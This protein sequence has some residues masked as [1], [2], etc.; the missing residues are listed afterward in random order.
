[1]IKNRKVRAAVFVFTLGFGSWCQAQTVTTEQVLEHYADMV[2]ANYSD[3]LDSARD[4][5][6]A[7]QFFV[8]EPNASHMEQAK[9]AWQIGREYYGQTEAFRF[10]GGPIDDDNGP[11]G[12]INAWP[13]DESYVDSVANNE[14]TGLIN[15]PSFVINQANI[16]AQNERG[17][18][19]NVASGWHAIEF[20]LWGQD[21]DADGPGA[22]SYE[23]YVVGKGT[24]AKRRADYLQAVTALL[25]EDLE[26]VT[27][28]WESNNSANYRSQFVRGGVDSLRKIFIGIGSLSRGELA[29]ERMEVA[30]FSRD[31]EDEHSCFSDNTHRDIVT[32]A[33]GIRNVWTGSYSNLSGER[34]E[35]PALRHLVSA[36]DAT[37]SN[38]ITQGVGASV[39]AA[40]AIQPPFD[41]AIASDSGRQQI[42]QTIELLIQQSD[43]FVEAASIIGIDKLTYVEP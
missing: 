3:T 9:L 41:Q 22:R 4:V 30:L 25:V 6:H 23:D 14:L 34:F 28:Q 37:L 42:Q 40:L 21:I 17:G 12:Q 20:L 7:V 15:D 38:K 27:K 19:E 26:S 5:L 11:E 31:Q 1:M 32:N 13:M 24:N 43:M 36:F 33:L 35:G 2:Y 8:R 39:E 10:Y 29:G 16:A 18:E